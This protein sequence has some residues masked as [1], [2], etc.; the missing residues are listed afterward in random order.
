MVNYVNYSQF[1][2]SGA[3]VVV[4]MVRDAGEAKAVVAVRQNSVHSTAVFDHPRTETASWI[5][6]QKFVDVLEV[7]FGIVE[8]FPDISSP[9][10][11]AADRPA[12][13]H[14]QSVP[15]PTKHATNLQATYQH[16]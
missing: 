10:F 4:H 7:R 5:P 13:T 12:A 3:A 8:K 16:F 14:G 1:L 2:P 11:T 15:K 6:T 9:S